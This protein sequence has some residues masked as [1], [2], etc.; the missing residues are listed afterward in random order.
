MFYPTLITQPAQTS[1]MAKHWAGRKKKA[2][3]AAI[4]IIIA[5]LALTT[6]RYRSGKVLIAGNVT[7]NA[8]DYY[9]QY[10]DSNVSGEFTEQYVEFRNPADAFNYYCEPSPYLGLQVGVFLDQPGL[11]CYG[12]KAPLTETGYESYNY[13]ACYGFRVAERAGCL[14]G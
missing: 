13:H 3:A 12:V 14:Y 7:L 2:A 4:L 9:E 8:T 11:A 6:P 10:Y 5:A 1:S